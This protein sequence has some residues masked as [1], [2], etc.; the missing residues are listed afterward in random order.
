MHHTPTHTCRFGRIQ[1]FLRYPPTPFPPPPPPSGRQLMDVG[2][3]AGPA[4]PVPRARSLSG[5]GWWVA[6]GEKEK[7]VALGG[8]P[9]MA[10]CPFASRAC[11]CPLIG[12]RGIHVKRCARGEGV[13]RP[14]SWVGTVWLGD[15]YAPHPS[16]KARSPTPPPHVRQPSCTPPQS[17]SL[18]PPYLFFFPGRGA[19]GV[20]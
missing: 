4:V 11:P 13:E 19:G 14:V 9:N 16:T 10:E 18:L 17:S 12:P 3:F 6:K 5:K 1:G 15:V 20:Y 2:R 8:S 7:R